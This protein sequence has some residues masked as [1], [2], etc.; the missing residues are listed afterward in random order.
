MPRYTV[1]GVPTTLAVYT[2]SD[3]DRLD[4][5]CSGGPYNCTSNP[6]WSTPSDAVRYKWTLTKGTGSFLYGNFGRDIVFTPSQPGEIGFTVSAENFP[7]DHQDIPMT[8]QF[9]TTV[10]K[11]D[12]QIDDIKEWEEEDKGAYILLND[13]DDN[14]NSTLDYWDT[15]KPLRKAE[16]GKDIV[17]P[18]DELVQLKIQ[19]EPRTNNLIVRL[20]ALDGR[21]KIKVWAVKNNQWTE[22]IIPGS[23]GSNGGQRS[24]RADN[25]PDEL[26]VEGIASSDEERDVVFELQITDRD[27]YIIGTDIVRLTVTKIDLD[28]DANRDGII[29]DMLKDD[30]GEDKWEY[31]KNKKG[32]IIICNNDNDDKNSGN[33]EIDNE[34]ETVDGED[35]I[36]DLTPLIIRKPA[37]LLPEGKLFLRVSDKSKCRI[38]DKRDTEGKVI[39]GPNSADEYEIKDLTTDLEYGVEAI[40]YTDKNF[41]GLLTI[42]LVLKYGVGKEF[43]DEVQVRVA[44]WLMLPNT[45]PAE[46]VY[47]SNYDPIFANRLGVFVNTAGAG[48]EKVP[49]NYSGDVWLQ[50]EFELGY[51]RKSPVDWLMHTIL[52]LPREVGLS[53]YPRWELMGKNTGWVDKNEVEP[54]S[55]L[56]YGG[57]IEVSPPVTVGKKEYKFGRIIYGSSWVKKFRLP[58]RKMNPD[59][60]AFLFAQEIQS[61]FYADTDWLDVGHIDE[62][63]SFVPVPNT[64]NKNDFVILVASPQQAINILQKQSPGTLIPRVNMTVRR[65]L[66]DWEAYNRKKQIE[67]NDI[68]T[69]VKTG[70][71]NCRVIEVP[72]Y[73]RPYENTPKAEALLPNMVNLLVANEHLIVAEPFFKPFR[74]DFNNKLSD[75]GYKKSTNLDATIHFIDDWDTYHKWGGEVH[76]GTNVKRTPPADVK[77][78]EQQP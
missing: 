39:I 46:K 8:A 76:C 40:S 33:N 43:K 58:G 4:V 66:S 44:P 6:T 63:I 32:A 25:L 64:A 37:I 15:E 68:V 12:L 17:V 1:V 72:V 71:G 47:V 65:V 75:L 19:L 51:Y 53:P 42:S 45:A 30:S 21:N 20:R 11:L 22:A 3:S 31:G 60:S 34:N 24:W 54:S 29:D 27:E 56:D 69:K 18:D 52:D 57:N 14:G 78:W 35:D 26:W 41:N 73:F 59:L 48:I 38:F 16:E 49:D 13:D 55:S 7:S 23:V 36:P 67:I 74:D 2:V 70:L 50:D 5:S 28:M 61:P 9:K 62:I 77:W 10:V